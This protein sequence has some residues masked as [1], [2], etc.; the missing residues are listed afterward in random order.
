[1][2]NQPYERERLDRTEVRDTPTGRAE[3]YEPTVERSTDPDQPPDGRGEARERSIG[4]LLKELRDETGTL[5]RQELA[6]AKTEMG[7][8]AQRYARNAV[9]IAAGATV[10]YM[11][12]LI[13]LLGTATAIYFALWSSGM[14][15]TLAGVLSFGAV[16]VLLALIGY[17]LIHKCLS[18]IRSESPVPEK[19]VQS[20]KEDKQWLTNQTTK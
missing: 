6:L 18:A 11:G 3:V 1:M 15:N 12:V 10:L 19:T 13:L 17:G 20:I 2:A 9:G 4:S 14:S 8:K 16:G 5:V 7:E